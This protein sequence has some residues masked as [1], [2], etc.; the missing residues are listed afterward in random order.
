MK[1]V[2][3][4]TPIEEITPRDLIDSDGKP[5]AIK[6]IQRF[7]DYRGG[8]AEYKIYTK[9]RTK[10]RYFPGDLVKVRIRLTDLLE[11]L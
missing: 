10:H 9:S 1:T 2:I 3:V 11:N 8:V 7:S 6:S 4:K 5:D